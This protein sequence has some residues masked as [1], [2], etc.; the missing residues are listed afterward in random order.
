MLNEKKDKS[1]RS[2]I[3]KCLVKK[4]YSDRVSNVKFGLNLQRTMTLAWP[5]RN[6]VEE[7]LD[8]V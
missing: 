1:E 2:H 3:Q 4:V 5:L 8:C 7:T 6:V